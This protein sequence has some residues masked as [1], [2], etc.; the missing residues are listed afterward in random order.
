MLILPI[1]GT[2]TEE[3]SRSFVDNLLVDDVSTFAE[4]WLSIVAVSSSGTVGLI[5]S[6]LL[7]PRKS[8]L[9]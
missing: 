7:I 2:G 4:T 1:R 6:F 8:Y 5:V 9:S 3:G